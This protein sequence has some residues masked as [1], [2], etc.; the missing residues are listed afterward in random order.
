MSGDTTV[1][2]EVVVEAQEERPE[3][4]P[5][6]SGYE[7]PPALQLKLLEKLGL[8]AV[9]N[10]IPIIG[11]LY[12]FEKWWRGQITFTD[13]DV[14]WVGL[15]VVVAAV[16]YITCFWLL[17]PTAKWFREYTLWHYRRKSTTVWLIPTVV[18]YTFWVLT[19]IFCIVMG[20]TAITA[21]Y[22]SLAHL[23]WG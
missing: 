6:L 21:M 5:D 16:V 3:E 2:T 13:T 1:D 19:W 15:A 7:R 23:I 10:V 22:G 11:S 17:M 4:L 9:I 8:L 20:V 14:L 12:V 18:A